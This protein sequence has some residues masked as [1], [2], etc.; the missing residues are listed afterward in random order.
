MKRQ[1][2]ILGAAMAVGLLAGCEPVEEGRIVAAKGYDLPKDWKPEPVLYHPRAMRNDI[3]LYK[4]HP[5]LAM[6]DHPTAG[7]GINL[8]MNDLEYDRDTYI[9]SNKLW[10]SLVSIKLTTSNSRPR[11]T[12]FCL[13]PMS[14]LVTV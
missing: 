7:F 6:F 1:M 13:M 4:A 3:N 2:M 8:N 9:A 12:V 10:K 11:S 14:K 5:E